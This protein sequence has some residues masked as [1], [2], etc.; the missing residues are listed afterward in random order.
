LSPG[1]NMRQTI[2]LADDSPTIQRL[3]TQTFADTRFDVVSVSNGDAA[4]K[5]LEEIQPDLVL[6]DIY[7]PGKNGYEVCAHVKAHASLSGTPVILLVGAFDAFDE[8]TSTHAGASAYIKKPFEPRALVELV[9]TVIEARVD[10]PVKVKKAPAPAAAPEPTDTIPETPEPAAAASAPAPN[11]APVP[12]AVAV[13]AEPK[14][15]AR[16]TVDLLGLEKLFQPDAAPVPAKGRAPLSDEEIDR[17]AER[18]TQKISLQVIESIAWDV[19][20]D[21]VTRILREELK[22]T[23]HE[24]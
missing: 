19:V 11:P 3:V 17:I 20:P 9:K 15:R 10:V 22:R 1:L 24:G 18:V 4:I 8:N 16:D 14:T 6:A 21:I 5:R 12:E 13:P 2:L 7:M 23:T